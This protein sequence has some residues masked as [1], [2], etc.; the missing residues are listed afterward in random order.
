MPFRSK[1]NFCFFFRQEQ[2]VDLHYNDVNSQSWLNETQKLF[3]KHME[4]EIPNLYQG[5][6]NFEESIK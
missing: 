3:C 5:P 6:Q 1:L 4:E 2:W